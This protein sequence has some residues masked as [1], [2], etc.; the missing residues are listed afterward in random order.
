MSRIPYDCGYVGEIGRAVYFFAYYEWCV[1]WVIEALDPGFLQR[2]TRDR[3]MTAGMVGSHL[4]GLLKS[5][6]ELAR[7]ED[8]AELHRIFDGLVRRRNALVHAS[9]ITDGDIAKSQILNYQGPLGKEISDLK[10]TRE[11]IDGFASDVD[12]AVP[13]V[14]RIFEQLRRESGRV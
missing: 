14:S 4:K 2:Y 13:M 5:R 8:L 9:P 11:E 1:V 7:R 12:A 3:A 6:A 10:W